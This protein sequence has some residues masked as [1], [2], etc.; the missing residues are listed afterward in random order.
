M[1]RQMIL[2]DRSKA[3]CKLTFALVKEKGTKPG[4]MNSMYSHQGRSQG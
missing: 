3:Q 2:N 4:L 1:L